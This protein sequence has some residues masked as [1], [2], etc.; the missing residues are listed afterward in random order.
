MSSTVISAPLTYQPPATNQLTAAYFAAFIALG[1][2]AGS[3]GPTLPA[4]A[5]QTHV[6]LSAISYLFTARSLGFALGAARAGRLFDRRPGN[7]VVASMLLAMAI[8][9][10]VV[11][12]ASHLYLLLIAMVVLGAA[13]AVLDVGANTLVSWVHGSRVA[14]YM[15]AMHSFFGIGALL[16]PVVV[17]QIVSFNYSTTHSYYVL[18]LLLLPVAAYTLRLSSPVHAEPADEPELAV[19][20]A[21]VVALV[22]LFLFFYVGA[23]TSFGGWIFTYTLELKLSEASTAAYLT[24]LF[25]GALTIGRIITIPLSARLSPLSIVTGSIAGCLASIVLMLLIP[26]SFA[27]V[28]VGTGAL[29]F[30]MGSVFPTTLSFAGRRMRMTG[31][32]TG[33]F[34]LGASAGAMI[35]PLIIGQFFKSIGP[36]VLIFVTTLILLS[37]ALVLALIVRS[38]K[39]ASVIS[40]EA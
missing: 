26:R 23:E 22:A 9:M 25:W 18:A 39:S 2:T 36:R 38:S 3:L 1:L 13:E 40:A 6:G 37:A 30:S 5:E 7:P 20:N 31:Q 35:V 21:R 34:V 17:A 28:V 14:P 27:V 24:S 11:P 10:S 29:G 32:V 12:F 15:N 19:F 16:A 33:W 8:M 4:L